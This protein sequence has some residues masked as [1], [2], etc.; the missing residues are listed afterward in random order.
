MEYLEHTA[1]SPFMPAL[2]RDEMLK[3]SRY[4]GSLLRQRLAEL[5]WLQQH[6][7]NTGRRSGQL[8]L[9]EVTEAGYGFLASMKIKTERPRGRGSF[10]HKYYAHKLKEHAEAT[11]RGC[12]ARIEDASQGRPADVTVRIPGQP[13]RIITFE[14][15]MTG[16]AKE[17]RGIARDIEILNQVIVCATNPGALESLQARARE[18]LGEEFLQ[19]V[20]FHLI[21]QYLMPAGVTG[22]SPLPEKTLQ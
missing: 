3:L 22:E 9:L 12:V 18:N 17:I 11:W 15:F 16:E 10:L 21:S 4:K 8:T 20:E 19:K 7:A 13:E 6:K 5:G 2:Q 1:R 14:I